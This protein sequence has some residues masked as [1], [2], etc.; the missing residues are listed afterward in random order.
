MCI[1]E[2]LSVELWMERPYMQCNDVRVPSGQ[3]PKVL[4]GITYLL[5][6]TGLISGNPLSK[7]T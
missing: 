4:M 7:T 1:V 3:K 6:S 2:R 5:N